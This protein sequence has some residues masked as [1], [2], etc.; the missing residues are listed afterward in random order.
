MPQVSLARAMEVG[1]AATW[2]A[3]RKWQPWALPCGAEST[4]FSW[5]VRPRSA[6]PNLRRR[7]A[8][9]HAP[10]QAALPLWSSQAVS[11][12]KTN[13]VRWLVP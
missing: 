11:H 12:T 13:S 10:S 7:P 1:G 6:L 8:Q 3:R 2:D 5:R 9:P 4:H